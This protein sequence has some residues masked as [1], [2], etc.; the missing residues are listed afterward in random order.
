MITTLPNEPCDPDGLIMLVKTLTYTE[1]T[2]IVYR[3][4]KV[5]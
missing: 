4:T 5:H 3:G 2:E 1:D